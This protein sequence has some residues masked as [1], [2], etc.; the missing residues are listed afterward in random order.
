MQKCFDIFFQKNLRR[1]VEQIF[2][3]IVTTG[4]MCPTVMCEVFFALKDAAQEHFAGRCDV[5]DMMFIWG[6]TRNKYQ[7]K[8]CIELLSVGILERSLKR[9]GSCESILHHFHRS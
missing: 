2:Q 1:Y 3:S 9:W 7:H 5:T 6:V 8:T 4:L